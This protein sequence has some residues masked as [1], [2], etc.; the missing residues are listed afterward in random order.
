MRR[1]PFLV[2][3]LPLVGC[4]GP[5]PLPP[6]GAQ[7]VVP[8]SWRIQV[9]P[10]AP[11]EADWW[12]AFS[13]PVLDRL[14]T[15]AL[16]DSP[17]IGQAAARVMEARAQAALARAQR[18]PEIDVQGV[19]GYTRVL[20]VIGPITTW[21]AEPQATIAYDFDLFGRLGSASA[22]ARANLLASRASQDAVAI[23]T[24]STV[25]SSYIQ[26][27]GLDERLRIARETLVAREASLK[28]ARRRYDQGYSSTLEL[29]Q[30][31]AEYRAT[32]QLVPAAE[33]AVSQQENALATL[34]GSPSM[35]IPRSP[36]ALTRLTM[37]TIPAGL[38]SDLLRRRPDIVA[39]EDAL[40]ASD[41]SLD[42]ARAAM[43]PSFALTG[44]RGEIIAEALAHPESVFLI[45]GSFLA[46][47][48]DSGKRR[49]AAEGAAARRNEAAFVY[50]KTVLNAF[51]EVNDGLA[52]VD[53]LD[54][55]IVELRAQVEAQVGLLRIA[56]ERYRAGYASYLDQIDA[57]RSLL[58]AQLSLVQV[59][60]QRLTAMVSLYE[61]M[62]GGWDPVASGAL[63]KTAGK[64]SASFAEAAR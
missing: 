13:D 57:Q 50:R 40:V 35:I 38:P 33:L 39:A 60:T 63:E 12:K 15:I 27:L 19:G 48:F 54:T 29:R 46:P 20:E 16:D 43:L 28:V 8:A 5:R 31:E 4:I 51:R 37:P 1:A 62:G 25:A 59:E 34:L 52:A 22:A 42:S 17:E 23:T 6:P 24:A 14:V 9:G 7:V 32:S 64:A 26:L 11:A 3:L 61:A 30:A 2:C 41:R 58:S 47:L 45:G 55:Q 49:A 53:R 10:S 36:G 18:G 21:G 44:S 56:S